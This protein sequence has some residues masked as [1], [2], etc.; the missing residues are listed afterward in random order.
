M[1]R[2]GL[3]VFEAC[4]AVDSIEGAEQPSCTPLYVGSEVVQ[5]CKSTS[6]EK[7]PRRGAR[8]PLCAAAA[9]VADGVEVCEA[10]SRLHPSRE[11]PLCDV[12]H[13]C[14][15]HRV[16]SAAYHSNA[17]LSRPACVGFGFHRSSTSP[18]DFTLLRDHESARAVDDALA[19]ASRGGATGAGHYYIV[20]EPAYHS[21]LRASVLPAAE[22]K[23]RL[24][25]SLGSL[26]SAYLLDRFEAP[27][28]RSN[29]SAVTA[30]LQPA[31][32]RALRRA[33]TRGDSISVLDGGGGAESLI[34]RSDRRRDGGAGANDS[35][36]GGRRSDL[37]G[38]LGE[39]CIVS[40]A[41]ASKRDAWAPALRSHRCYARRHHL[42]YSLEHVTAPSGGQ[43]A[44]ADAKLAIQ[45]TKLRI[46]ARWLENPRGCSWLVWL[47]AD[48]FI[49]EPSRH[50]REWLDDAAQLVM[51]D[52]H[53]AINNG[54]F[55]VRVSD[56]MRERFFAA[57]ES[58]TAQRRQS[59]GQ[60][61]YPFTDNG[62][63]YEAILRVFAAGYAPWSC[64]H[65]NDN[66][67][68]D[69]LGCV[70]GALRD[71][72]GAVRETGWRGSANGLRLYAPADG[73]NAHGCVGPE[74]LFVSCESL[75]AWRIKATDGHRRG[76]NAADMYDPEL[77]MFGLHTKSF[78]ALSNA[79]L[80]RSF[81]LPDGRECEA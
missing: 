37:G 68:A 62:S 25:Q 18:E 70:K 4:C 36:G 63:M 61:L 44:K 69:F 58:A 41:D 76:W 19:A 45:Y 29:S 5:L 17:T 39:I 79:S 32:R 34:A 8:D 80:R 49:A 11:A 46:L 13:R 64:R 10:V 31:I 75:P 30:V 74:G 35:G 2:S 51:T 43:D 57:W 28:D 66:A 9:A 14:D 20:R 48:L 54:A 15:M 26:P 50:L 77:R 47:D 33:K 6:A 72:F 22:R 65:D 27:L 12:H 24:Q 1:F 60:P 78:D 21:R 55:I 23:D 67:L 81:T 40:M 16:C 38:D 52:H 3:S 7:R 59:D 56:L 42:R 71:A 73:F 53:A